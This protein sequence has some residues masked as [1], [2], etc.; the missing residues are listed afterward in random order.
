[1]RFSPGA[2]TAWVRRRRAHIPDALGGWIMLKS[3]NTEAGRSWRDHGRGLYAS[4]GPSIEDVTFHDGHVT[5]RCSPCQS[6]HVICPQ[7][8]AGTNSRCSGPTATPITEATCRSRSGPPSASS[9]DLQG[10]RA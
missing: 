10:R 9:V 1:M 8:G 6:V 4:S 5:V 3:A 2:S 7:P